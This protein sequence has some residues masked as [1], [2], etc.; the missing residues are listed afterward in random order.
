ML[1]SESTTETM[2]KRAKCLIENLELTLTELEEICPTIRD[3][4]PKGITT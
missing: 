1:K 3:N 2:K 4:F